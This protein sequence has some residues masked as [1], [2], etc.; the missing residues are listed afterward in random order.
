MKFIET[1]NLNS[2]EKEA[3]FKLWNQEYP[4]SLSYSKMDEFDSYL[5]GLLELYHVLVKDELDNIV[6]WYSDFKRDNE[7]WFA[8]ILDDSIQGKGIG[9]YLLNTAKKRNKNLSG[10]VI[11]KSENLK[12]DDSF[13]LSP[14]I[15]YLKNDFIIE[16]E[17]RLELPQIS[18]VKIKWVQ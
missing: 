6:G 8:M 9:T 2:E 16:K 4:K 15:F 13:Y 5:N 1:K 17:T 11:D 3:V 14:L 7:I 10:W 18:A 12:S